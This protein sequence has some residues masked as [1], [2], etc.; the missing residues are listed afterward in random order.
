MAAA[1]GNQYAARSK[2][3]LMAIERALEKR[4]K[5]QSRVEALDALAEKLLS[6]ADAGEIGAL[7]ELGDRLDGKAAQSL[8]VG[9]DADNPLLTELHVR[10]K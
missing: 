6:L 9:G 4:S 10:F 5:G 7:K 2:Q 1:Q 8:T 3:W